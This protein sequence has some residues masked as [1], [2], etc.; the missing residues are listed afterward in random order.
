MP[1]W[2]PPGSKRGAFARSQLDGLAAL[3]IGKINLGLKLALLE[4]HHRLHDRESEAPAI[5]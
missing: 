2:R 1:I 4:G 3:R 5:G